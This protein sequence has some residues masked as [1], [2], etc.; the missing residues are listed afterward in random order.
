MQAT[1]FS[2]ADL[3]NINFKYKDSP[4]ARAIRKPKYHGKRGRAAS[5][6]NRQEGLCLQCYLWQQYRWTLEAT[7]YA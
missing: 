4:F 3:Q 5:S 6:G 1:S 7:G 2:R